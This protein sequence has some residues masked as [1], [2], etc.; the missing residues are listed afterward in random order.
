MSVYRPPAVQKSGLSRIQF[1]LILLL[2]ALGYA[3]SLG[4]T[5]TVS[6]RLNFTE[7]EKQDAH[8]S[9]PTSETVPRLIT[10]VQ[11]FTTPNKQPLSLLPLIKHETGVTHVIISSLHLN[12]QPGDVTLNDDPLDSPMYDRT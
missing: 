11:T 4:T 2:L 8:I 5:F 12:E 3:I 9:I 1:L 7:T 10:Y 6:G